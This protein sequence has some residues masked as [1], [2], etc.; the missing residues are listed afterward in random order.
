MGIEKITLSACMGCEKIYK[1][2]EASGLPTSFVQADI[3]VFELQ[4]YYQIS[5]GYCEK[6]FPQVRGRIYQETG[7]VKR[8]YNLR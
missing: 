6:C 5:H 8:K 3:E 2:E 7:R 1:P 4:E